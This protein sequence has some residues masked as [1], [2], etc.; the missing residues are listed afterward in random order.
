[1][2]YNPLTMMLKQALGFTIVELVVVL[3]L[4]GV[5]SATAM[6]RFI[7][8]SAFAPRNIAAAIKAQSHYATQHA[9]TGSAIVN[10]NIAAQADRWLIEA[11]QGGIPV[12]QAEPAAS[13]TQLQVI[14]DGTTYA[15]TPAANFT[16]SY[17]ASGDVFGAAVGANA[18]N[19]QTGIE[20]QVAGDTT[21]VMCIYPTGYVSARACE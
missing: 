7:E 6:S 16:V 12:R 4:L 5:L 15:I 10:L 1:M 21:Q 13:N 9:L 14:N 17:T 11:V 8:P 20:L 2:G 19:V 3:I 18:L